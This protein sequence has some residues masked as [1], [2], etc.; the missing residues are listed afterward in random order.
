M[1]FLVRLLVRAYQL[2]LSPVLSAIA[3]PNAG[4]RFSP[5]CSQYFLDAVEQ[6]GFWRGTFLGATRLLR[7]QPWGGSGFDPVP[8]SWQAG[9]RCA[10]R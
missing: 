4:C 6:H 7:C 9:H 1:R 5:T 10:S 8:Q 2:T 3:G